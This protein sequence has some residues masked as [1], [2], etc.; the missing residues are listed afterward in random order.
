MKR[1]NNN[2]DPMQLSLW[3]KFEDMSDSQILSGITKKEECLDDETFGSYRMQLIFNRLMPRTRK[4][5]ESVIEL[6]KR[7]DLA[8]N[9]RDKIVCS[10]SVFELL[11]PMI[12]DL[13]HEEFWIIGLNS[14]G[15]VIATKR[16]SIGGIDQTAADVRIIFRELIQMNATALIAVHNHPSG[17]LQPSRQ[18]KELT[19]KI[20]QAGGIMSIKLFDH[21]IIAS[22]GYYSFNDEGLL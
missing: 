22:D 12:G 21:V 3:N 4:V 14:N 18:D 1:K 5:A 20:A 11:H 17:N 15:R 16:I 10:K 2:N 13:E 7:R 8:K 6:Y 19:K 9:R